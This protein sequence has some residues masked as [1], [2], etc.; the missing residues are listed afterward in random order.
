[1]EGRFLRLLL[2]LGTIF[3]IQGCLSRLD[4]KVCVFSVI[5]TFYALMLMPLGSI[6]FFFFLVVVVGN[7]GKVDLGKR[8]DWEEMRRKYCSV[9][10]MFWERE[11]AERGRGGR[12]V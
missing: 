7:R 2:A 5:V 3:L 1:M 9:D 6:F 11:R 12:G 10:I 8:K 4:M